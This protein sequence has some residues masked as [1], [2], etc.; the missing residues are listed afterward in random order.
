MRRFLFRFLFALLLLCVC[1]PTLAETEIVSVDGVIYELSGEYASIV[2]VEE[3]ATSIII[4]AEIDGLKTIVPEELEGLGD[5][6]DEIIFAE[7][8][9]AVSPYHALLSHVRHISLPGSF[10]PEVDTDSNRGY[11]SFVFYAE[12]LETLTLPAE[13]SEE[14]FCD[15]VYWV[16]RSYWYSQYNIRDIRDIAYYGDPFDPAINRIFHSIKIDL[17]HPTLY[18]IDGIVYEKSTDKL[19]VCLPGRVGAVDIPEGTMSIDEWAFKYCD[20]IESITLPRSLTSIGR[21]A[22]IYCSSLRTVQLSPTLE[23]IGK[24]AFYN[25]SELITIVIPDGV[26]IEEGAFDY[27]TSLRAVYVQGSQSAIDP[28]AFIR[29]HPD[30]VIYAKQGTP[31]YTAAA[32]GGTLW[33]EPGGMP[34]KLQNPNRVHKM[35][36]YVHAED[37]TALLSLYEEPS[38]AANTVAKLEVGTTVDVLEMEDGWAHILLYNAEGFLPLDQLQLIE[39][40]VQYEKIISVQVEID[41]IKLYEAPSTEAKSIDVTTWHRYPV[42]EQFG[43]WYLIDVDGTPLYV[44]VSDFVSFGMNLGE[45]ETGIVICK[46]GQKRAKLYAEDSEE[47]EVLGEYYTGTQVVLL[48]YSYSGFSYVLIDGVEGFI[49]GDNLDTIADEWFYYAY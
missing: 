31:G 16:R 32:I 6:L 3:G 45:T 37:E 48:E 13:I 41:T 4:H 39:Q 36:A 7:G 9:T 11:W 29:C 49:L 28:I 10:S 8:I 19:L 38:D 27:C 34:V 26:T 20:Q 17:D 12:Y 42:T 21:A 44:Q 5:N 1:S 18:D 47:S 14:D 30:L 43:A 40:D 24:R 25:C 35:P 15:L 2:G 22:F 23:V 46:E 33:A